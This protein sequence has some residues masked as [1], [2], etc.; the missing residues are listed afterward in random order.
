MGKHKPRSLPGQRA[1]AKYSTR[2]QANVLATNST[3]GKGLS[4]EDLI[5]SFSQKEDSSD[6]V[7]L[8]KRK[9]ITVRSGKHDFL[10]SVHRKKKD[11]AVAS[12]KL[13]GSISWRR[14][15]GLD[16]VSQVSYSAVERVHNLWL[17]YS[18]EALKMHRRP[19]E[20]IREM[21]LHG[22]LLQVVK[23]RNPQVVGFKGLVL[24]D[25]EAS[26]LLVQEDSHKVRVWKSGSCFAMRIGRSKIILVGDSLQK[27]KAVSFRFQMGGVVAASLRPYP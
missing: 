9:L 13:Q 18:M 2:L 5:H 22:A 7:Q 25:T 11:N 4:L 26:F 23:S 3:E 24:K 17:K 8:V 14:S 16:N 27:E 21:D 1:Y 15:K 12:T 20:A 10:E 19:E 6:R